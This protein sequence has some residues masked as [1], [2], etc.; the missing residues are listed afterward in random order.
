MADPDRTNENRENDDPEETLA[1]GDVSGDGVAGHVDDDDP[2]LP[3]RPGDLPDFYVDQVEF[4][5]AGHKHR[6]VV[7]L[8]PWTRQ[9][10]A[11]WA[12][13]AVLHEC[14]LSSLAW[15]PALLAYDNSPDESLA[16]SKSALLALAADQYATGP[17]DDTDLDSDDEDEDDDD[18]DSEARD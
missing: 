18:D 8:D 16:H 15:R 1:E 4:G 3:E 17:E 10:R 2:K 12:V 9:V 5:A 11:G 13:D 7:A 14:W 6:M